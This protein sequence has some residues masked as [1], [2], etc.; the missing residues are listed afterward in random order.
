[1]IKYICL[2]AGFARLKQ[3]KKEKEKRLKRREKCL[4]N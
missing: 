4:K 3:A 1:M 2:S